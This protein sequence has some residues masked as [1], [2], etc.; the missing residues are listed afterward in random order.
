MVKN[1]GMPTMIW[2]ERFKNV[3]FTVMF[4]L[5]VAGKIIAQLLS[6]EHSIF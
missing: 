1:I 2:P 4:E 5:T 3:A 6:N